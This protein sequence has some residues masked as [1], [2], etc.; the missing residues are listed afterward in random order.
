MIKFF[1]NIRKK[2]LA[3]GKTS[4]YLKYAIGEIILVVIGI[5]IALQINNWN[6]ERKINLK[7]DLY[8]NKII[9]DLETD[10]MN[11]DSF[12]DISNKNKTIVEN[13]FNFFESQNNLPI[14]TIIDSCSKAIYSSRKYRYTPVDYTFKDMQSSG[15]LSLLTDD[16]RASLIELSNSQDYFLIV[17]EKIIS[18]IIEEEHKAASYLDLDSSPSNFFEKV[19]TKINRERQIQG[20]LHE[21]IV[22]DGYKNI[23]TF[24]ITLKNRIT[25]ETNRA[26]IALKN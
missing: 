11:I 4:N 3:E 23:S 8:K 14:Q 21:H 5:L 6:E 25:N 20:L 17:L 13:Y 22:L 15:N 1:R 26:L 18:Q 24:T 19:G 12:V 7:A 10:L 9:K 16:Q 2:L